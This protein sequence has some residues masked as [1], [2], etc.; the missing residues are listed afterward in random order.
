M[1]Y[2]EREPELTN[3]NKVRDE[4]RRIIIFGDTLFL[5]ISKVFNIPSAFSNA[6]GHPVPSRILL[7]LFCVGYFAIKFSLCFN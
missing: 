2:V 4:I 7:R 5:F 3:I 6:V 1:K